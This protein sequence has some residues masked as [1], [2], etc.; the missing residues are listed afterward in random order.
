MNVIKPVESNIVCI[1]VRRRFIC[2][3][4]T[5]YSNV[6]LYH[7]SIALGSDVLALSEET[8]MQSAVF[9]TSNITLPLK[10]L[11]YNQMYMKDRERK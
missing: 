11:N 9:Q 3:S 1:K 2:R 7:R 8:L 6:I 10:S 5:I 4:C